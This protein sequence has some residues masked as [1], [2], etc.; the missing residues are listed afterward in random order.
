MDNE[1]ALERL[2]DFASTRYARTAF[3][4]HQNDG[5]VRVSAGGFRAVCVSDDAP[6]CEFGAGTAARL[7]SVLHHFNAA[8][9]GSET[10]RA[11]LERRVQAHVV[12]AALSNSLELLS[13]LPGLPFDQLL[14]ALDEVRLE[15]GDTPADDV[16]RCDLLAVAVTDRRC[17]PVVIELKWERQ[18]AQLRRQ[19][20]AFSRVVSAH[21]PAFEK[22]LGA[23]VGR[24]GEVSAARVHHVIVWPKS[25]DPS[26]AGTGRTRSELVTANIS[27][28]AFERVGAGFT[29]S[30]EVPAAS[31][32]WPLP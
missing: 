17:E 3:K 19:L 1:V 5:Y 23:A 8:V 25:E 13:V 9:P 4:L 21:Q 15:L 32:A 18:L 26:S 29:F 31:A 24:P 27:A 22:L 28:V 12:R 7:D 6:L 16:I 11:K 20:Q 30:L 10:A 14:F 2:A